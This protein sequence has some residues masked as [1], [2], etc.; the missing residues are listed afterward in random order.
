ML[1]LADKVDL[2]TTGNYVALSNLS[3]YHRCK[4][5]KTIYI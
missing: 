4:N 2:N 3:I 5:I 1:N